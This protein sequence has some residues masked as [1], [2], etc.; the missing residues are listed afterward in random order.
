MLRRLLPK[1]DSDKSLT[2]VSSPEHEANPNAS[3]NFHS[4]E[5]EGFICPQCM[6]NFASAEILQN[7]FKEHEVIKRDFSDGGEGFLCPMCKKPLPSQDALEKH[8]M[9]VHDGKVP[10]AAE[11]SQ[12]EELRQQLNDEQWYV[13][14]LKKELE[15]YQQNTEGA[16][17]FTKKERAEFEFCQLQL[18]GTEET[19]HLVKE[20]I[21]MLSQELEETKQKLHDISEEKV[22]LEQKAAKLAGD[23]V[24][25]KALADEISGQKAALEDHIITLKQ[26]LEEKVQIIEKIENRLAQRPEDDDVAVLKQELIS[27]QTLMDNMTQEREREKEDLEKLHKDLQFKY[28]ESLKRVGQ[29]ESQLSSTPGSEEI[30]GLQKELVESQKKSHNQE[31]ELQQKDKVVSG[32]EHA[33]E[34]LKLELDTCHQQIDNQNKNV[35]QLETELSSCQNQLK[36]LQQKVDDGGEQ[37]IK[38]SAEHQTVKE[39][40]DRQKAQILE[41]TNK[42]AELHSCLDG[43]GGETSQLQLLLDEKEAKLA[44]AADQLMKLNKIMSDKSNE[45]SALQS[46]LTDV[47]NEFQSQLHKKE[48]CANEL[49]SQI[50]KLESNVETYQTQASD[51]QKQLALLN[52]QYETEC[53][54]S[55]ELKTEIREKSAQIEESVRK[56]GIGEGKLAE[57]ESQANKLR[58]DVQRLEVERTDLISKIEAGEGA[59]TAINQM[60]QEN[61]SLQEKLSSTKQLLEQ[62]TAE[63]TTQEEAL[64]KQIKDIKGQLDAEKD[65]TQ[66]LELSVNEKTEKVANCQLRIQQ[67]EGEIQTKVE[68]LHASEA[69]KA[70][71]RADLENHLQTSRNLVEEKINEINRIKQELSQT[72]EELTT[73]K[74]R[75]EQLDELHKKQ[76]TSNN[77]LT[78]KCSSLER[79]LEERG[80]II[81]EKDNALKQMEANLETTKKSLEGTNSKVKQATQEL[82]KAKQEMDKELKGLN[83]NLQ[84]MEKEKT[85]LSQELS[86]NVQNLE[87]KTRSH[88]ELGKLH[89]STK[90]TLEE[91]KGKFEQS[92]ES[93]RM[94]KQD[95]AKQMEKMK[96]SLEESN[97]K[98][99]QI[100]QKM[101]ALSQDYEQMQKVKQGLE[102]QLLEAKNNLENKVKELQSEKTSF[103]EKQDQLQKSLK[104]QEMLY[105]GQIK[106]HTAKISALEADLQTE[107]ENLKVQIESEKTLNEKVSQMN[108]TNAELKEQISGVEHKLKETERQKEQQ[109]AE[110][111]TCQEELQ[112]KLQQ[113]ETDKM[114]LRN[115]L[116]DAEQSM[117]H[118]KG[119]LKKNE[120]ELDDV[121]SKLSLTEQ[122][123]EKS[124]QREE[125][126]KTS[127]D[128]LKEEISTLLEAKQLL[129]NQKLELQSKITLLEK[130]VTNTQGQLNELRENAATLQS[131]LEN[132]NADLKAQL[133]NKETSYKELEK[134][135]DEN[136][137]RYE[138]QA[139]VLNENLT[140]VRGDLIVCQQSLED[141]TT[142]NDEL[143]G[144]KLELEAKLEN[145][146]DERKLLLERCLASEAECESLQDR[147]SQ[148]T[149]KLDDTQAAL[150]ELGR[151]NQSLQ[152]MTTKVQ[153]RKWTDDS[154]V[155]DC[156]GCGKAF[157]LTI[158]KHHCRNCG[159]IFCN[160]CSARQAPIASA[161]KPVRVCDSCFKELENAK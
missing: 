121:M 157:S 128:Q 112:Q 41:Y 91:T 32:L 77:Q 43:K 17:P 92:Q 53:A 58:E 59:Q 107:R 8:Y 54:T 154:Q 133:A 64:Y 99:L 45:L 62:R 129:I 3:N 96:K 15:K 161:K 148:V 60:K 46:Q 132:A 73:K 83:E 125:D 66:T 16:M 26:Q 85:S 87:A 63:K 71:Q 106:E 49:Q 108:D 9:S 117:S 142:A 152:I 143:L 86:I 42:I 160:E 27:V 34:K 151:E 35:S 31:I 137:T 50:D 155:L 115:K 22:S 104:E 138:M 69:A 97:A 110:S 51:L 48:I 78:L 20:Q 65:H 55:V 127:I 44:E 114:E 150:Q 140:T 149:R 2:P 12:L 103:Q 11:K 7:H 57:V 124:Q 136:E 90:K 119:K 111:A 80:K 126:L 5:T 145:S 135:C 56:A 141:R 113:A 158:R 33:Q 36:E 146:N 116:K 93:L 28:E 123:L 120:D 39:D 75:I 74:T 10:S 29:L 105:Q 147:I 76:T 1:R 139:S 38:L 122:Q 79:D 68:L 13:A 144:Q 95:N 102:N 14:E 134:K 67:L 72:A 81:D 89:E 84:K 98:C 37:L 52:Q 4:N 18:K 23:N 130:Q 30:S 159:N 101:T 153:N 24:T 82:K 21:R 88:E 131:S 61:A 100:E 6:K 94:V 118:V 47:R 40:S 109:A 25:A 19:Q 70:T 156:M